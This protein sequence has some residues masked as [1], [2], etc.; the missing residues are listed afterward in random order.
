VSEDFNE[1][2]DAEL[3]EEIDRLLVS[4]AAGTSQDPSVTTATMHTVH[5]MFAVINARHNTP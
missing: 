1:W 3:F 4:L 5:E 2:T